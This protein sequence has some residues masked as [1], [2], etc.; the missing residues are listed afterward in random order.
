MEPAVAAVPLRV[1]PERAVE[2]LAQGSWN[3]EVVIDAPHHRQHVGSAALLEQ[4]VIG[5]MTASAGEGHAR[6]QR[7]CAIQPARKLVALDRFQAGG[8]RRFRLCHA[9]CEPARLVGRLSPNEA[10]KRH[11]RGEISDA[12][13]F[14]GL[15]ASLG[16]DVSDTN[17][18]QEFFSDVKSAL[19]VGPSATATARVP[20]YW[21]YHSRIYRESKTVVIS[22]DNYPLGWRA[23]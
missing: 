19:V 7:A 17:N 6:A 5:P 10:W 16:I 3:P 8:E 20:S 13:F 22:E 12:A 9:G 18:L 14:E 4:V 21:L 2:Q 23:S 1:V 11:E 15:R